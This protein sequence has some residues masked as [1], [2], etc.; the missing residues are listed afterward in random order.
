MKVVF[1]FLVIPPFSCKIKVFVFGAKMV[2]VLKTGSSQLVKDLVLIEMRDRLIW[3]RF[4]NKKKEK[5]TL[6]KLVGVLVDFYSYLLQ[7][8]CMIV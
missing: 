3:I 1:Y 6:T 4:D 7:C 8:Q 2:T 5:E